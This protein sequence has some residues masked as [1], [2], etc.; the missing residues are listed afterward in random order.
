MCRIVT[1]ESTVGHLRG[2]QNRSTPARQL[3]NYQREMKPQACTLPDNCSAMP[4]TADTRNDSICRRKKWTSIQLPEIEKY[5]RRGFTKSIPTLSNFATFTATDIA[6]LEK[7]VL[8]LEPTVPLGLLLEL[9]FEFIACSVQCLHHLDSPSLHAKSCGSDQP[10]RNIYSHQHIRIGGS[11]FGCVALASPTH[12]QIICVKPKSLDTRRPRSHC[13]RMASV[14]LSNS[15]PSASG[16][17]PAGI[18]TSRR[19][20]SRAWRMKFTSSA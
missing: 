7:R 10:R 19:A 1:D 4:S 11:D 2:S 6:W 12:Y 15:T 16:S 18:I 8:E 3:A 20:A 5:Q 9:S 17:S 13:C 14:A